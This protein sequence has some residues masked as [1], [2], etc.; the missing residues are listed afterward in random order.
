MESNR[1]KPNGPANIMKIVKA[2]T[3]AELFPS[4]PLILNLGK[5]RFIK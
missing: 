3:I 2:A 1:E 5:T 4:K